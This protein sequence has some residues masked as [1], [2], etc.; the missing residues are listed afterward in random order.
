MTILDTNVVSELMRASPAV[1]GWM[2]RQ[3]RDDLFTTTIT[4]AEILYG[5]EILPKGNRRQGLLRDAEATFRDDFAGHIL[6]FDETAARMFAVVFATRRRHGRPV[7]IPDAQIAAIA[8]AQ[9]ATLATRNTDDFE[10][11][12]VRLVNPW[13]G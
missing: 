9:G 6:P 11:C 1:S 10:G 8:R 7:G 5:V 2:S 4:I 13:E 12:C 3:A